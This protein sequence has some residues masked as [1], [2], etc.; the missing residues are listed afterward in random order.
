[1]NANVI[2][3][4]KSIILAVSFSTELISSLGIHLAGGLSLGRARFVS[5]GHDKCPLMCE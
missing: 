3:I 1:M 5:K 4:V 2:L